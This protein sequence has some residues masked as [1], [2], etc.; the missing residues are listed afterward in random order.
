[1]S[2]NPKVNVLCG[3]SLRALSARAN[4]AT[5]AYTGSLVSS[6]SRLPQLGHSRNRCK[7]LLG[8]GNGRVI[9][10]LHAEQVT[11]KAGISA[12]ST[13]KMFLGVIYFFF[14][15]LFNLATCFLTC[16]TTFGWNKCFSNSSLV[17]FFGCFSFFGMV[18]L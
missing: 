13:V 12:K 18:T 14:P 9:V 8:S 6:Q 11:S 10:P 2:V 4:P 7:S 17:M 5:L 1:M 16:F 15:S 3:V